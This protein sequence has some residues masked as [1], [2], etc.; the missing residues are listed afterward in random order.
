VKH[1]QR[2]HVLKNLATQ[3]GLSQAPQAIPVPLDWDQCDPNTPSL[4]KSTTVYWFPFE[5]QLHGI[6]NNPSIMQI[7]HI[8][9]N[10]DNPFSRY[11]PNEYIEEVQDGWNYQCLLDYLDRG[12]NTPG[13]NLFIIGL[14][15]YVKKTHTDGKG[16]FCLEPVIALLTLLNFDTHAQFV[17]QICLGYINDLDLSSTAHKTTSGKNG[18][19]IVKSTGQVTL[20]V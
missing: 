6:L 16:R 20:A 7:S 18:K 13:V 3:L 10:Q 19:C 17:S 15:I 2:D 1:P 5:E 9:V 14:L 11:I 8:F 12:I 4:M